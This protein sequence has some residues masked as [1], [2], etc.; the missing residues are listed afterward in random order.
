MQHDVQDAYDAHERAVSGDKPGWEPML[1]AIELEPGH[2]QM[3][4]QYGRTYGDI[5]IVR[6]GAEVGY[7][8]SDG[9]GELVG[10]FTTLRASTR[11]VHVRYIAAH[12]RAGGING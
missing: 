4:A 3:I 2:W 9:A 8:A 7:R 11:A 12:S 1:A 5:R 10:Y 6:R